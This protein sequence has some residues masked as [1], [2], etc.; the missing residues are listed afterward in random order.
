MEPVM[1]SQ[2]VVGIAHSRAA[3][4][5]LIIFEIHYNIIPKQTL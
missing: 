5:V 4:Q 1:L 2:E 3:F